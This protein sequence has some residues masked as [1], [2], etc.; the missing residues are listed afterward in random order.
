MIDELTDAAQTPAKSSL[1]IGRR[2]TRARIGV[3][4]A[5]FHRYWPQFPGLREELNGYRTEFEERLRSLDV[6]VIS[7]GLVDTVESGRNAGDYFASQN[8]D[9]IFCF[10][11]TY[12][13]SAFVVPVAQRGKAHMV[14]VGLQ[15]TAGMNVKE[16][17]THLQ[18]AHDNCT[19]LPEIMYALRRC[20]LRADTVFGKLHDDPRSEK[21][22]R[23][24]VYAAK[25]VHALKNARIGLLGHPFEGM[26]DMNVDPTSFTVAFGMHVDMI[27]MGDLATRVAGVTEEEIGGMIRRIEDF[28]TFPEPGSDSTITGKVTPESMRNAARVAVGLEK[29]V[30]DYGLDG[31]SHYYRGLPGNQDEFLIANII[32]GAS[33]LTAQGIPVA[34]E[35]D[36]KNCAAMLIMD[37]LDAGGSFCELHPAD[38]TEDFVFIGHDG[39]GHIGISNEA[40]ALRELSLYH[41]KFGNGVSVE[42][43]VKNGP[44]TIAGITVREDG[45][46]AMIAAEG[47]SLPGDIPETGN[48]NT[49]AKFNPDMP[50]FIENW[51]DAGVTHH[52]ALGVGSQVGILKKIG[53]ILNMEIQVVAQ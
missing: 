50:T 14:L 24:W 15:P 22:V 32:V 5:G 1:P 49:R 46:F 44:I 11:T 9:L 30:H 8:V 10:V 17:T 42:F 19:S 36:L 3:F 18:L 33:L 2:H 40:P 48:T 41:G 6:E 51:T 53:R 13:Q 27:E 26:L 25:A 52:F 47:Q 21:L 37:R 23:E 16:V 28:F 20:H 29:L 7:G 45:R 34:G 39:P 38:F 12:V 4:N 43:K 35:G 31:L